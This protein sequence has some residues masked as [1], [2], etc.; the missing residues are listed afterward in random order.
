[1]FSKISLLATVQP[2]M[3]SSKMVN[4]SLPEVWKASR[5][6]KDVFAERFVVRWGFRRKK[7]VQVLKTVSFASK[8]A[9]QGGRRGHDVVICSY[10][11]KNHHKIEK[12]SF[13]ETG[14]TWKL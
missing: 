7:F 9:T 2:F 8:I 1:M 12:Y 14:Q 10:M 11:S 6:E 5:P 3:F 13:H 4:E